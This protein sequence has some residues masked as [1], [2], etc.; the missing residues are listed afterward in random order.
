VADRADEL[1]HQFAASF[2]VGFAVGG[3]H[4]LVDA[5]GRFDLDVLRDREQGFETGCC[6]SVSSAA[7]VWRVRR[8]A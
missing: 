4:V 3:D 7:P 1:L 8:A 5:P 2:P 6:F